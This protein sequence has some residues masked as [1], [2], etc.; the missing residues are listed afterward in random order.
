VL[1]FIIFNDDLDGIWDKIKMFFGISFLLSLI[2]FLIVAIITMFTVSD[3]YEYRDVRIESLTITDNFDLTGSFILGTGSIRG[4]NHETYIV[5]VRYP[6]GI[7]R[8]HINTNNAFIHETNKEQPHIKNFE[9]RVI[10]P[11]VTSNWLL[12]RKKR[13]ST[14]RR[15]YGNVVI[16]VP[17]NTII[18]NFNI[19]K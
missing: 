13:I 10:S 8:I 1:V 2:M 15:N 7:K 9:Y 5:H 18:Y 17:E 11:E 14:W 4:S 3:S 19:D 6:Q 12:R 16:V